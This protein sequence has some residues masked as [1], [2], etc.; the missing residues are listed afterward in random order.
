MDISEDLGFY[1]RPENAEVA[2]R[3]VRRYFTP[4]PTGRF[5]GAHFERLGG[6]GDRPA[7][8]DE[9]TAE[10]LVAVSMLSVEV[11]R[12]AA[13]EILV[14][15]RNRLH[16]L[17]RQVPTDLA[18]GQVAAGAITP[19][20]PAWRLYAEL[21]D[22]KEIGPTTASKLLARKRP[23]LVPIRDSVVEDQL[24]LGAG[25]FWEP[26]RAWLV[27]G[28]G[29]HEHHLERVRAEAGLGSDISALR[30]FDVLTWLVGQGY[31]K[32]LAQ[33]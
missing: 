32:E 9:F 26:L 12:D 6:G 13:L 15:R 16:E 14:H 3:L 24:A 2:A 33:P 11:V 21:R 18:L 8:A 30:V 1:L 27:A 19:D 23:H 5:T 29:A 22:I 4:R 28:E 10:D 7:I 31:D 17:L 20:W 25:P